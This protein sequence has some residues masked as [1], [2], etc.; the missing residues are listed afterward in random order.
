VAATV[1]YLVVR[2]ALRGEVDVDPA[3][4]LPEALRRQRAA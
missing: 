4:R 3:L 2:A 1:D